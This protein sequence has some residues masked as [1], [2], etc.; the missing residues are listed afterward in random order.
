MFCDGKVGVGGR[1]C[2]QGGWGR[3]GRRRVLDEK[4]I[5]MRSGMRQTRW[6]AEDNDLGGVGDRSGR[7]IL[8]IS[9]ACRFSAAV[10]CLTR[11]YDALFRLLSSGARWFA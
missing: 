1:Q 11:W 6:D 4:E 8:P 2:Y 5:E 10:V 9:N 3:R 7:L